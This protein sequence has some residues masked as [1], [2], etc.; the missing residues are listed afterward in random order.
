[1]AGARGVKDI[2]WLLEVSEAVP[3]FLLSLCV[4]LGSVQAAPVGVPG[5]TKIYCE[6]NNRCFCATPS[7]SATT[8]K[9]TRRVL[10]RYSATR[11]VAAGSA[12]NKTQQ[13]RVDRYF[14]S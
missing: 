14:I 10:T 3:A 1:M 6:S 12:S 8:T 5:S 4:V 13:L 9:R 2:R 7:D 11:P